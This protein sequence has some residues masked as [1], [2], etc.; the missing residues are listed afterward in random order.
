MRKT[1]KPLLCDEGF[2]LLIEGSLS[3]ILFNVLVALLLGIDLVVNGVTL[4][5]VLLWFSCVL[6]LSVIRWLHCQLIIRHNYFQQQK[7]RA[8]VVF[9]V[10]TFLMGCVWGLSYF[11]FLKHV[12]SAHQAILL[13]VLGGMSAGAMTSLSV[14]LPAYYAY[15]LP[16][17]VPII[18]YSFILSTTDNAIVAVMYLLFI[19]MLFVTARINSALLHMSIKLSKEKDV[20]IQD[21]TL[22][23]LKLEQSI[24]EVRTLSITDSLT[25]LYNR[26]YFDMIFSNE[27]SRAK[28]GQYPI[29]LIFIDIDN[30]K[31]INDT[32]GHPA[33]DDFLIYVGNTLKKS[34]LRA[35]DTV[36]RLGGDEFAAILSNMVSDEVFA[37]CSVIQDAF[38][39][40]NIYQ[41]VTLSMGIIS[42]SSLNSLDHQSIIT[43]AD[44]T[45][46][47]AKKEGKNKII[48]RIC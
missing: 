42:I 43:A 23:N 6:V 41:N 5:Y 32:Y 2:T 25:G 44:K 36:F 45:L 18:I 20:L 1:I 33:G 27:L 9:L 14:Y 35:N 39:K 12:D 34:I 7:R 22:T 19:V 37:F 48:S 46:Y 15:V 28:R 47:Q 11:M 31:F 3:S 29:S 26:R 13:L 16:I 17:F 38:N 4:F 21:M 8:L 24:G 30:F 40:N 10:L